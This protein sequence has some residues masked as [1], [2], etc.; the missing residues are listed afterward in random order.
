MSCTQYVNVY[1]V[2]VPNHNL[3]ITYV[4]RFAEFLPDA[5]KTNCS[6]CTQKQKD[7]GRKVIKFLVKNKP[8]V[9]EKIL[10]KFDPEGIYT[11]KYAAEYQKIKN[12]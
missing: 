8:D 7:G 9:W 5:L 1:I 6:K 12:E 4:L 2:T 11:T 3:V 10:K